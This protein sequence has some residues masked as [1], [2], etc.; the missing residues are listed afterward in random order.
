VDRQAA[1]LI[2]LTLALAGCERG[3][4]SKRATDI[5]VGAP[6][7]SGVV[8]EG[9]DCLPGVARCR[10]GNVEVSI[11]A[12]IATS[13][14]GE[15]CRCP[16]RVEARCPNDCAVHGVEIAMEPDVA[17][18]QL[19]GARERPFAKPPPPSPPA[20]AC[21]GAYV[22]RE[23]VVT[24]CAGPRAVARCDFGCSTSDA[25]DQASSDEAAVDVLCARTLR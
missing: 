14:R 9:T 19:C 1:A 22:C 12:H 17:R 13:C 25:L 18:A 11:A 7:R 21:E 2:A 3:C 20:G 8:V 10:E 6:A 16:F 5:G 23:S 15:S 4:L 24:S